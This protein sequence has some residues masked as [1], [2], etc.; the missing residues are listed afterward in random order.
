MHIAIVNM[1]G[2]REIITKFVITAVALQFAEIIFQQVPL[3]PKLRDLTELIVVLTAVAIFILAIIKP[4]NI[5]TMVQV[6]LVSEQVHL[7]VVIESN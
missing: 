5:L 2:I 4:D 7:E 6:E 1:I 3:G